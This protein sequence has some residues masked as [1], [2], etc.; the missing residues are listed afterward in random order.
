MI[1]AIFI[2]S[3]LRDLGLDLPDLE[4]ASDGSA[5]T[6]GDKLG[7]DDGWDDTVGVELGLADG[8]CDTVGG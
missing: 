8:W 5:D 6:D 2:Y 1:H 7:F 3:Y 4:G